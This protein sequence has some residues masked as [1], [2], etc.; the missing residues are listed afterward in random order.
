MGGGRALWGGSRE[1]KA[2]GVLNPELY[3][4]PIRTAEQSRSKEDSFPLSQNRRP[5]NQQGAVSCG[6]K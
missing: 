4:V 3:L 2:T 1:P 6:K 5:W